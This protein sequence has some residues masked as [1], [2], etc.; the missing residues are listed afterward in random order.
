MYC[1]CTCLVYNYHAHT[2]GGIVIILC[3]YVLP[4]DIRLQ[5]FTIQVGYQLMEQDL[6]GQDFCCKNIVEKIW[7]F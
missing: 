3:V 1:K 2:V 7:Q 5:D 6:K 4:L